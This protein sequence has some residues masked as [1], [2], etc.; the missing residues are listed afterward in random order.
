MLFCMPVAILL[1]E[2][3]IP[4]LKFVSTS[5]IPLDISFMPV[6]NDFVKL[7]DFL[8]AVSMAFEPMSISFDL[9]VNFSLALPNKP[10]SFP[11]VALLIPPVT[12]PIMFLVPFNK[13][14]PMLA[15][16]DGIDLPNKPSTPLTAL[17]PTTLSV[18]TPS[19]LPSILLS[20]SPLLSPSPKI[21]ANAETFSPK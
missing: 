21:F 14:L 8:L 1:T 13:D 20:L 9:P 15:N 5:D 16:I 3:L 6:A 12:L 11:P 2:L 17:K 10:S 18:T 7:L 19:S 4:L